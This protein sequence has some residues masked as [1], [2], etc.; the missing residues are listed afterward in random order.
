MPADVRARTIYLTQIG[1]ISMQTHEDL[2]TRMQRIPGYV[3]IFTGVSTSDG[4]IQRFYARHGHGAPP[5]A[6]TLAHL[7]VRRS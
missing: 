5:R 7:R 2:S 4:E 6:R 3:Q 1:Y